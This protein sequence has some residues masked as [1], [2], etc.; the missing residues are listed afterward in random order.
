MIKAIQDNDFI[1]WLKCRLSDIPLN[2]KVEA[3]N[4]LSWFLTK[5]SKN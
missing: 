4:H 5:H 1:A 3:K 2:K